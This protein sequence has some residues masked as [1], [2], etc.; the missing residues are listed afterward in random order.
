MTQARPEYEPAAG[1]CAEDL[2][3]VLRVYDSLPTLG[4]PSND[5]RMF[6]DLWERL[7][8][9]H[10]SFYLSRADRLLSAWRKK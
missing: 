6:D 10:R 5:R 7:S 3:K 1:L 9:E 2:A 4:T 8:E